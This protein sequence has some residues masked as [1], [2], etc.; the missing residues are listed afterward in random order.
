MP[1]DSHH[2]HRARRF[3]VALVFSFL[4]IA[5]SLA[6]VMVI[7]TASAPDPTFGVAAAIGVFMLIGIV[8]LWFLRAANKSPWAVRERH[9][10]WKSLGAFFRR[11]EPKRIPGRKYWKRKRNAVPPE[12][13]GADYVSTFIA[14]K[15]N[16]GND[17]SA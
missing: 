4:L 12:P 14:D 17:A 3:S 5:E 1:L 11:S 2:S 10:F 8:P 9:S 15:G 6:A 13:F 16:R 7:A